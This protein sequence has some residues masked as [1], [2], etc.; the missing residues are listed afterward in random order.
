MRF[1][2]SL[3]TFVS[4]KGETNTGKKNRGEGFLQGNFEIRSKT[5]AQAHLHS[6]QATLQDTFGVQRS[7]TM[8]DVHL[9]S[10]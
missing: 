3:N 4:I 6:S 1:Q 9:Q 5:A 7:K 10:S 2:K 8:L